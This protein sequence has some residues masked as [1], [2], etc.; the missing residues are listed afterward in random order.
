[1][2]GLSAVNGNASAILDRALARAVRDE[3]PYTFLEL[4]ASKGHIPGV[5]AIPLSV[6]NAMD[7][8]DDAANDNQRDP[9]A[10][11][12]SWFQS[13]VLNGENPFT[14]LQLLAANGKNP[15]V[16]AFAI[17]GAATPVS[18]SN[19]Q[20]PH[21]IADVGHWVVDHAVRDE[22]PY[23]FMELLAANGQVPGVTA[24]PVSARVTSSDRSAYAA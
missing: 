16:T 2:F 24:H 5:S 10:R 23:T 19:V 15:G 21:W 20:V 17:D 11:F 4:L 1:M 14:F 6:A 22:D 8:G 3:N 13:R 18:E 12:V 9:I 7:D